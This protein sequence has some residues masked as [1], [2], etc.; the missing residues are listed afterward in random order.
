MKVGRRKSYKS[1]QNK[2]RVRRKSYKG[3]H[4]SP[5]IVGANTL[6]LVQGGVA[7]G[8]LCPKQYG[9]PQPRITGVLGITACD[10]S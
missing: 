1:R 8:I 6:P 4:S 9:E 5:G 2:R 7:P 10:I 3:G